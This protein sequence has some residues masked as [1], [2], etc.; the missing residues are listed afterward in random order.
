[1]KIV[2]SLEFEKEV[3]QQEGLVLVDFFTEW[4]GYCEL[5]VPELQQ[6]SEELP[7]VK[8]VKVN[9]E[10]SSDVA[11]AYHIEFYPE[12]LLFKGGKVVGHID[13]Y[14]KKDQ[15]IRVLKEYL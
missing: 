13:G 11:E 4:C 6:A 8:F 12:M 2:K 15:I 5:L 3:L 1:M 10:T 14:V 7:E 9:A